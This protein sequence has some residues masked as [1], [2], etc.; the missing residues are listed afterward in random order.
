MAP[1]T[2]VNRHYS[3]DEKREDFLKEFFDT[4][5]ME[6][7]LTIGDNWDNH[8]ARSSGPIFKDLATNV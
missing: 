4:V 5:P 6:F 8:F 3:I 2:I 7:R 1:G